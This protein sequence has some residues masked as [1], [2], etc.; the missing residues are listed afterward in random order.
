[1]SN[2]ISLYLKENMFYIMSIAL[3]GLS[4]MNYEKAA[5]DSIRNLNM[6]VNAK[7]PENVV[8]VQSALFNRK[9]LMLKL[10]KCSTRCQSL[11]YDNE[12]CYGQNVPENLLSILSS[13]RVKVRIHSNVIDVKQVMIKYL[14]RKENICM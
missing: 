6:D 3:K 4:I 12:I 14:H 7:A 1:M 13:P 5:P 10:T 8:Y 9:E 2:D 11:S